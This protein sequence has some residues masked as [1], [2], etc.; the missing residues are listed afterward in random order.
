MGWGMIADIIN[1]LLPNRKE[2]YV[3]ELNDLLVR[4]DLALKERRDTDAAIYLK[5]MKVLRKKLG[6]S[7]GDV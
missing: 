5:R 6:Y 4:Y 7:E 2:A 3:D 1:K